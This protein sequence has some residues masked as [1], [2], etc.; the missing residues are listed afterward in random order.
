MV[1]RNKL[2]V[3]SVRLSAS[4][5]F[6]NW[7]QNSEMSIE[8]ERSQIFISLIDFNSTPRQNCNCGHRVIQTKNTKSATFNF[9]IMNNNS[10]SGDV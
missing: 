4:L 2:Q 7:A 6:K 9:E 10:S 3:K 8:L 1:V 5:K